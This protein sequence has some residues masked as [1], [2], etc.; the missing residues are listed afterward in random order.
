MP[1]GKKSKKPRQMV[2]WDDR[3]TQLVEYKQKHDG[4]MNVPRSHP[5]GS[6]VNTQRT[7]YRKGKIP[8]HRIKRLDDIGFQWVIRTIV[9][10]G[11]D[12]MFAKLVEYKQKHGGDTNV[13]QS[14]KPL[15]SWVMNQRAR[16]GKMSDYCI[17]RLDDIGFQWELRLGRPS[18]VCIISDDEEE[19]DESEDE[20]L[21]EGASSGK[22]EMIDDEIVN[23]YNRNERMKKRAARIMQGSS[24]TSTVCQGGEKRRKVNDRGIS[25]VDETSPSISSLATTD[26]DELEKMRKEHSMEMEAMKDSHDQ[27]MSTLKESHNNQTSALRDDLEEEQTKGNLLKSAYNAAKKMMDIRNRQNV[28]LLQARTT[29][30]VAA[31]ER[32]VEKEKEISQ[33]RKMYDNKL[34]ETKR[35][36]LAEVSTLQDK[37]KEV[38][39]KVPR[40]KKSSDRAKKGEA[41]SLNSLSAGPCESLSPTL[42]REMQNAE[43]R[44]LDQASLCWPMCISLFDDRGQQLP[45]QVDNAYEEDP[46]SSFFAKTEPESDE[47]FAS[48]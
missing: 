18:S 31:D 47:I 6:W 10:I 7:A 26:Q 34:D 45:S 11:W 33:L 42:Q 2:P 29:Y 37:L 41:N 13:P 16:K 46:Q 15:G 36:H 38:S 21:V 35:K 14:H 39:S 27:A 20:E 23:T 17:K 8:G 25:A 43:G 12:G 1:K 28:E 22:A 30:K 32:F 4:D 48:V 40:P 5:L 9:V 3:F 24:S 44:G 19:V